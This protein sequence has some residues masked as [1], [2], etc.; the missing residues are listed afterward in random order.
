ML[1]GR[2]IKTSG[3]EKPSRSSWA[4]APNQ[5]DKHYIHTEDIM[6]TMPLSHS[7]DKDWVSSGKYPQAKIIAAS[8]KEY[9]MPPAESGITGALNKSFHLFPRK[10]APEREKE[11]ESIHWAKWRNVNREEYMAQIVDHPE[12]AERLKEIDEEHRERYGRPFL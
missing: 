2:V 3:Y 12:R 4:E 9:P 6:V 7:V 8:Y 11:R 5:G 10:N 1:V